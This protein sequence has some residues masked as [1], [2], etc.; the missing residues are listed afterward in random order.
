ME[1]LRI[2]AVCMRSDIGDVKG[3]LESMLGRIDSLS[4]SGADMILFPEMCLTGYS[5]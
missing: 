3:N 1:D 2:A 4:R 5:G